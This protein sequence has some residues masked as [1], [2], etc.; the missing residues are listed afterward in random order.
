MMHHKQI[1]AAMGVKIAAPNLDGAVAGTPLLVVRPGDSVDELK[2]TVMEVRN[3]KTE[4]EREREREE[5]GGK[6]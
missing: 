6:E 5:F 4:R 2:Q 3:A 1:Q